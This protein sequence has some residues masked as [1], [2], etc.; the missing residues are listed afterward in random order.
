MLLFPLSG[1]MWR[2]E[3]VTDISCT[4]SLLSQYKMGWETIKIAT[5]LQLLYIPVENKQTIQ[6]QTEI[7]V[8]E[9]QFFPTLITIVGTEQ[10]FK[11]LVFN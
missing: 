7:H 6:G 11:T 2:K 9:L 5:T 1:L 3:Y 4:G 10:V 8:S